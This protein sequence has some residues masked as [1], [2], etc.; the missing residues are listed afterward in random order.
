MVIRLKGFGVDLNFSPTTIELVNSTRA[1][2]HDVVLDIEETFAGVA[3]DDAWRRSLQ[4]R[5][6]EAGVFAPHLPV[7]LGGRG[8]GMAERSPVFEE[9]GYS[10]FGALAINGAAPDEGNQHLLCHVADA[11]QR[12]RYLLPLARGEIRSAFA[13]SEPAPG[14]GS[15]PRA[16][17]SRARPVSGGWRIDGRKHFIT[18]ADGAAFLIV[19]ARTSGAPGDAQGA[20]M[21]LVD[22]DNRGM[23]IDR[24]V[25]TMDKSM[26][27]GHCEV[28]FKDCFV[29]HAAVLGEADQG[30][31]Y[32][33]IRLGPARLTHCMRWLGAARRAHEL[34]VTM[35]AD[36]RVF[37][38][39]LSDLG[40]TQ[41]MIA[42]SEIDLAASRGLILRGC[43]E[44]DQDIASGEAVSIAKTF[45]AEAVGRIVDRSVQ[46]VG[47][48]GVSEDL[49][50]ARIFREVRPFRIYDGPSEVHRWALARR[51]TNRIVAAATSSR[52]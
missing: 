26:I 27:G 15:D 1:F 28:S 37:G 14:A 40:M 39:R 35:A 25:P 10:L 5:A 22:V 47:G 41:Q 44:I 6:K 19:M 4:E 45:V 23:T 9:A 43:W 48:L 50:L 24:H 17:V 12:V 34:A 16:L 33:S 46:M 38:E 51:S 3:Q 2:V 32:A 31:R 18:G 13:M 7:E 49:P 36:R 11:E 8:L 20:T 29:P 52:L 30:F 42:D 21:F